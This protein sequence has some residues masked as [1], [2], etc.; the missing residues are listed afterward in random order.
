MVGVRTVP[1]AALPGG[2]GL[3]EDLGLHRVMKPV[4]ILIHRLQDPQLHRLLQRTENVPQ[5]ETGGGGYGA[6]DLGTLGSAAHR[7]EVGQGPSGGGQ[8]VPHPSHR[9]REIGREIPGQAPDAR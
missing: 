4:P 2:Q 3:H 1:P 8:Q 7:H 6:Q 5:A 9:R